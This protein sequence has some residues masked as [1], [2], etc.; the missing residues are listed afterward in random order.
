MCRP[1]HLPHIGIISSRRSADGARPLIV[2]NIGLGP[3]L[4]DRLFEFP[5]TGHYRYDGPG[6]LGNAAG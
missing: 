1:P 3:R 4:E 5:I 2:H 6:R